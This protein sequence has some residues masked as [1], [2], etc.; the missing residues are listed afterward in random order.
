LNRTQK[1]RKTAQKRGITNFLVFNTQ[2][3]T[4]ISGFPAAVA[5]LTQQDAKNT[6]FVSSVN[7]EQAKAEAK[8]VNVEQLKRGENLWEKIA[9]HAPNQ[10]FAVDSLGVEN[11]R[12]LA[13]AV[14]GE[15]KLQLAGDLIR[16][17]RKIKDAQEIR[18][19]RE[20]CRLADIGIQAAKDTVRVGVSE[21]MVAAEAEYAM[22]R[23]GSEGVA[24]ET[25]VACDL[26]CAYPHGSLH[27][28]T[29]A[30]GDFVIVDLGATHKFYR[31]DITRTFFAGKRS[32]KQ[33]E[34]FEVAKL[35]QQKAYE[36]IKP[37]V[38]AK[39]VDAAARKVI[40]EAGFCD[41]FVHNLGHGVGLEVHE[42]PTLSP[43]SKDILQVGNVVTVEPGIYVPGFGGVRLED[44]VLVTRT[45]AERLTGKSDGEP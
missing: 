5:L 7:F 22:R 31:S 37:G 41:C 44:T 33:T 28:R 21:R 38:P 45:G 42:A 26:C 8:G 11:W 24:F 17:M 19:I 3:I 16:E 12:A 6:L 34:I 32:K 43:D 9:K 1:L 36:T 14:G 10:N 13:K 35:A 2:N 23:A 27:N 18:L 25:I 39:E 29:I 15:E 40:E 4:Y 20:A 30:E